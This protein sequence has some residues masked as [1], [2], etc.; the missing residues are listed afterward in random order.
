MSTTQT[1][2]S[3]LTA[4]LNDAAAHEH[5]AHA[6]AEAKAQRAAAAARAAAEAEQARRAAAIEQFGPHYWPSV[7][8]AVAETE[9]GDADADHLVALLAALDILPSDF[10]DDVE[11]LR[12]YLT[13]CAKCDIPEA[14]WHELGISG[15][16]A[17]V[18]QTRMRAARKLL[19]RGCPFVL[20][21][22][23]GWPGIPRDPSVHPLT[24]IDR[25]DGATV[26]TSNRAEH[27]APIP[28]LG[29]GEPS[30]RV[31]AKNYKPAVAK[32][33]DPDTVDLLGVL[34]EGEA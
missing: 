33:L 20:A 17:T 3:I 19:Q 5:V 12:S 1:I 11:Q 6:K 29:G 30:P 32:G 9:A 2:S 27:M 21:G 13:A 15:D 31:V 34:P 23:G 18:R 8:A 14:G 4:R 25:E 10:L 26:F 7:S 24:P 28:Q 16:P 22:D